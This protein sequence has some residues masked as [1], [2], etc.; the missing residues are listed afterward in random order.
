MT[1]Y[2]VILTQL[3]I[4][5]SYLKHTNQTQFFFWGGGFGVAKSRFVLINCQ[6]PFLLMSHLSML[7]V[8]KKISWT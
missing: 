8:S 7:S 4:I 6:A 5:A 2:K 3:L 1:S